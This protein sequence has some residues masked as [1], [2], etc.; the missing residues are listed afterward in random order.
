LSKFGPKRVAVEAGKR[1]VWCTCRK[2]SDMPFCDGTHKG[3]EFKP[4]KFTAEKDAVVFFCA[5]GK[6]GDQPLCDG[7]HQKLNDE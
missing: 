3:S 6:T 1:Y 2:S 7:S 5:C 4:V